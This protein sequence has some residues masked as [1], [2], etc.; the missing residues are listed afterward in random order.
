MRYEGKLKYFKGSGN[1][2]TITCT[3]AKR[4]QKWVAYHLQTRSM[5]TSECTQGPIL[6]TA[7]ADLR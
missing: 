3:L 5:F 2:K 1:F 4:H 6:L 7:V